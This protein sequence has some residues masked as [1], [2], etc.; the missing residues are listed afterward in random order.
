[1]PIIRWMTHNGRF[2]GFSKTYT[3]LIESFFNLRLITIG[4]FRFQSSCARFHSNIM[5]TSLAIRPL[6]SQLQVIAKEQLNEEPDK[7]QENLNAFKEWIRKSPHLKAR[8][9]D[10]FLVG[11]LRGCKYSLERAKQKF[12]LFYTLRTH[13][14]EIMVN[15][16][17]MIAKNLEIMRC[18]VGLPM[19]ETETPGSPRLLLFRMGAYDAQKFTIQEVMKVTSTMMDIMMIEDDNYMIAGQVGVVDLSGVTIHHFMQMQPAFMKKMTMLSQD[20]TPVRQKGI[21]YINAPASF[22]QIYNLF[23]TFMNEKMR[24]R[25]R[26]FQ[27]DSI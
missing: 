12:D 9:D 24:S 27:N 2:I 1:M 3:T 23:K 22:E 25:V 17:P 5:S 18:G 26:K 8:T 13:M 21:H 20:A 11:F 4:S 7:I 15:R 10:Q 6:N 16:D 19:L 14:P